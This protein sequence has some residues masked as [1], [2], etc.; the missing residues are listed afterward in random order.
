MSEK[1]SVDI[2]ICTFRR[3]HLLETLKSVAALEAENVDVRVIV[4]DNDAEPS[5][6][7]LV[8]GLQGSFPFPLVYLH[9]PARNISIARNACVEAATASY[10]AFVDDDETVSPQWLRELLQEAIASGADAVLGPVQAEYDPDLP[11]WLKA[12]DFHS[13]A[14]VFVRGRIETGYTCNVLIRR[15]PLAADLRFDLALGGSGGE[16]TDF[17]YR[18]HALGGQISFAPQALVR[19]PVPPHRASLGWLLN[20][21][22]RAGQ[23][24]ALCLLRGGRASPLMAAGLASAKVMHCLLMTGA[25]APWPV[26]WRRNLLRATLHIGVVAGILGMRQQVQYGHAQYR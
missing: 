15:S 5:A 23:T 3:P 20:R 16:D 10:I 14:P 6:R 21:R 25:T 22:L 12:G 8:E 17:F 1:T 4:A 26:K 11:R 9:S 24:H 7:T 13:A 18:L 19:E 2:C